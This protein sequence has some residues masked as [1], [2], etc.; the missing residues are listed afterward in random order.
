MQSSRGASGAQLVDM[1]LKMSARWFAEFQ[2]R[3]LWALALNRHARVLVSTN[4]ML[5]FTFSSCQF[6]MLVLQPRL[7]PL[8]LFAVTELDPWVRC[9]VV[10]LDCS[11][12][13]DT[14][15]VRPWHPREIAE[16]LSSPGG[17]F[18]RG[19]RP[20]GSGPEELHVVP[21]DCVSIVLHGLV[22][23]P[24]RPGDAPALRLR[25]RDPAPQLLHTD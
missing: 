5:N 20:G 7:A 6:R 25:A 11:A 22:M 1:S 9:L 4:A 21:E 16:R 12:C 14:R 8:A 10:A 24:E 13:T 23:V 18:D 19:A 17:R 3:A 2:G 15:G